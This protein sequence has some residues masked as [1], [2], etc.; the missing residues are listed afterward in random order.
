MDARLRVSAAA[1]DIGIDRLLWHDTRHHHA[2]LL[3][4]PLARGMKA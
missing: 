1:E 3:T 4:A 2:H